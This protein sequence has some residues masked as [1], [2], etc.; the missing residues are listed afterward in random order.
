V[1]RN[2]SAALV[3]VLLLASPGIAS[4]QS[5]WTSQRVFASQRFDG[6]SYPNSNEL[7]CHLLSSPCDNEH[8]ATN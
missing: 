6:V 4:A 7:Y 8:R 3:A 2:L 5:T 1:V